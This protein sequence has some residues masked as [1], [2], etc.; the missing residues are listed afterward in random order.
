MTE[1]NK[2]VKDLPGDYALSEQDYLLLGSTSAPTQ[3]QQQI[4][5]LCSP[6][7]RALILAGKS[8]FMI[9]KLTTTTS[10]YK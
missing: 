4:F 3:L 8:G 1:S 10:S 7:Y 2:R 5:F 6:Y 9:I